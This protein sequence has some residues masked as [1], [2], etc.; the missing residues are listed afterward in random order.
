MLTRTHSGLLNKYI[1]PN[2]NFFPLMLLLNFNLTGANKL[3]SFTSVLI[4]CSHKAYWFPQEQCLHQKQP[5]HVIKYTH[6]HTLNLEVP[7]Y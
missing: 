4:K 3:Y 1:L 7:T 6:T 5:Q 2:P